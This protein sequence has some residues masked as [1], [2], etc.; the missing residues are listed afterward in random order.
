M[1]TKVPSVNEVGVVGKADELRWW[2]P[3]EPEESE[4]VLGEPKTKP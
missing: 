3:L 2:A 4:E 1:S